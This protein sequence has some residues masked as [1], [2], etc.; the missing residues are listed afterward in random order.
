[1]NAMEKNPF[2][3]FPKDGGDSFVSMIHYYLV[4]LYERNS[5]S[6]KHSSTIQMDGCTG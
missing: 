4:L 1:M 6:S 2:G 3:W 5:V